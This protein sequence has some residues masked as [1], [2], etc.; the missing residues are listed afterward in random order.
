MTNIKLSFVLEQENFKAVSYKSNRKSLEIFAKNGELSINT[1]YDFR[2]SPLVLKAK[3]QLN[4][5]IELV[6]MEH[7]IELYVEGKICDEEWPAGT[8]YFSATD[9]INSNLDIKIEE[10]VPIDIHQ[11]STI[12]TFVNASGWQPEEN[13]FVGDCMPY[14]NE[15]R[16]HVLYLKDRHHHSSKWCFGAHQWEHISTKDFHTWEIHPM[17]VKITQCYEGS[18]CTGSWIK[19]DDTEY[20]FYTIRMAD[21]SP[22][23]ICR[24]ISYD[25]YHFEKDT[26]FAFSLSS[27]YDGPSARD[28]K[29]IVDSKGL[30]HMI[31]TTS[32]KA[33]NKGCLAH[34]ISND[35][36]QWAELESPI[37]TAIDE[38]QPECPDYIH[39]GDYY[40]LIYSLDGRAH[41][42]YSTD[43]FEG[44]QTPNDPI[45]P[46]STVPKGAVW[47]DKIIFTGFE[48]MNGYGGTMVFKTATSDINGKLIFE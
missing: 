9:E 10:Y 48:P 37:Y 46:C 15:D 45:I 18:I 23:R 2:E 30:Y 13:V 8:R 20:L 34:L 41:Y 14:V 43:P 28:P 17:A 7:R 47:N 38:T 12:G 3:A 35:L 33:E 16:Y 4:D 31:L 40:Y 32:L 44:W 6:L 39:F 22:A 21:G 29:I 27:K 24:S 19:K 42:Q 25:G 36:T 1:Y 5:A 26:E 11:P